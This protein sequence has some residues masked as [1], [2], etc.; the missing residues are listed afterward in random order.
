M[1]NVKILAA[2]SVVAMTVAS[3]AFAGGAGAPIIEGEPFVIADDIPV[4]VGAGGSLGGAV[5]PALLA[6]LILAGLALAPSSGT[7]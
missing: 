3:S 6:A 2:A 7:N 4:V 5:G 1:K